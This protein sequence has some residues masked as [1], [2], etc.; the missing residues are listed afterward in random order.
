MASAGSASRKPMGGGGQCS[1][2]SEERVAALLEIAAA[3]DS[4]LNFKE[5]LKILAQKTAQVCGVDRCSIF[6][7]RE[8]RLVPAMSQFASG[9]ERLDMWRR[10]KALGPYDLDD[11]GAFAQAVTSGRPIIVNDPARTGLVPREWVEIFGVRTV[12]VFPL[13]RQ[14]RVV[15]TMHLD[16]YFSTRPMT[17]IEFQ[18]ARVI[19]TQLALAI[20]NAR[21]AEETR[22]RLEE[23]EA[24]LRVGQAVCS[25]LDLQ[26]V[27]RRITREAARMLGADTASIYIRSE[28]GLLHPLAGYHVPKQVLEAFQA[29][30]LAVNEFEHV[31]ET[32]NTSYPSVWSD[33]LA[34]DP[35]FDRPIFHRF[36]IQSIIITRLLVKEEV[37]GVL[38]CVWWE[39]CHRFTATE[40]RLIEGIAGQAALAIMNARLYATAEKA[41]VHR[42]RVRMAR[43]LHDSLSLGTFTMGLRLDWCL[44]HAPPES[45]FRRRLEDVKIDA[46]LVMQ[47]IRQLICQL[48]TEPGTGGAFAQ[49]LAR[50]VEEFRE[51]SGIRVEFLAEGDTSRLGRWQKEAL[52]KSF[53]EALANIV[54]HASAS[55]VRASL[56]IVDGEARFEVA[57]DGMGRSLSGLTA[58]LGRFGLRQMAERFKELGG[59]IELAANVPSGLVVRGLLPIC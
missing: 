31:S 24:L 26:E 23:T 1:T 33:N 57:D 41:A 58:E 51:L 32:Q 36:K 37:V 9:V 5:C 30:P 55:H 40:R 59:K 45:E 11:V 53:Q 47:Q 28:N 44:H 56:T 54:K 21:L 49:R 8:G 50:L 14:E 43:E 42:E 35:R 13:L 12:L 3:I 34:D 16:N 25:T 27:A 17:D 52:L 15:G 29:T 22:T 39:A 48:S 19:A 7:W 10:F 38:I 18:P 20:D 46:G 6:L 4:A 2:P